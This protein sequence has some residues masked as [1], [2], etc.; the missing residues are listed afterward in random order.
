MEQQYGIAITN[1]YDLF[2]GVDNDQDPFDIMTA[3][4]KP[5]TKSKDKKSDGKSN[6]KK[7]TKQETSKSTNVLQEKP[8]NTKFNKRDGEYL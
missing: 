8:S 2:I 4:N 5:A 7:N 1:K 6:V 3:G